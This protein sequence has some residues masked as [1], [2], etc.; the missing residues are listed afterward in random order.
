MQGNCR[1]CRRKGKPEQITGARQSGK[2]ISSGPAPLL[3]GG[4]E[5]GGPMEWIE[6][7]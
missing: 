5:C 1:Q 4:P 3:L 6:L 2:I 7:A